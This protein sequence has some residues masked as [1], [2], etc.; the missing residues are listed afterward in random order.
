M[1]LDKYSMSKQSCYED[2]GSKG[3]INDSNGFNELAQAIRQVHL[4]LLLL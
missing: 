1:C 3:S 4:V 2:E